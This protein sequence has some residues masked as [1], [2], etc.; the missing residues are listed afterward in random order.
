MSQRPRSH[1]VSRRNSST[2]VDW[3]GHTLGL[4][5]RV[6]VQIQPI[7]TDLLGHVMNRHVF[8]LEI[9]AIIGSYLPPIGYRY[10]RGD[11]TGV[12]LTRYIR[13]LLHIIRVRG[14]LFV[15]F[16]PPDI[17]YEDSSYASF[18]DR[19]LTNTLGACTAVHLYTGRYGQGLHQ[20]YTATQFKTGFPRLMRYVDDFW[21]AL[22]YWV[23]TH[24]LYILLRNELHDE[25]TELLLTINILATTIV[26]IMYGRQVAYGQR[27]M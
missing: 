4:Y 5:L 2:T 14:D 20:F 3:L 17:D 25:I 12:E 24:P 13:A 26:P 1:Y 7:V 9:Q 6:L 8:P 27:I 19:V 18:I 21:Q 16:R 23:E 11:N 10:S 15:G 22:E